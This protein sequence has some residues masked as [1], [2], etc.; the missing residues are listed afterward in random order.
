MDKKIEKISPFPLTPPPPPSNR[1]TTKI[2]THYNNKTRRKK[3]HQHQQREIKLR[4][5]RKHEKKLLVFRSFRSFSMFQCYSFMGSF[6]G[7]ECKLFFP[8]KVAKRMCSSRSLSVNLNA[9][10]AQ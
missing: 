1:H 10:E 8:K 4:K 9:V 6:N 3:Q 7:T 5:K 2:H